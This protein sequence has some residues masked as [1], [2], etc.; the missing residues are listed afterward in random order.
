MS[1]NNA[2][3]TWWSRL[4][5]QGLLLSPVV[6]VERYASAPAAARF[7]LLDNLRND[8]N[9]FDSY[10]DGLKENAERDEAAILKWTDALL[11][12][13]VQC[14]QGQIAKQHAIPPNLTAPVRIGSRTETLRPH[15]VVFADPSQKAVALL[16]IADTSP[17][18]G[19]GRGRNKYAQFLELLRGT[20]HRL[21]LLTNGSQFRLIYAG[22]DFESWCEWESDRWFDGGEGTEELDGL[23]QLLSP[24]SLAPTKSGMSSLLDAVEE[25]RKRQAD[26]S[27]V[28]RENVRQAV[29]LLLED[30]S[31]AHRTKS[32]LFSSLSR[33]ERVRV[34]AAGEELSS[35]D[36]HPLTDAEAHEALLQ[37]TVRIVMRLVVCL[38]AESRQLLP[39]NDP[40]YAQAYG[41]RSLYELLDEAV[42][43]EGGTHVLFNRQMAW[44]R[45]MALFRLIHHGSSHGAF[46]MRAYGGAL[47]R[48]GD[49]KSLNAVDRALHILE[50]AVSVGDA[51]VYHVLRKLLRGPLPVVK[52]HQKTFVDGPVDYT[53]LRTEFIGLIYEGLLDYRLKRTDEQTGPQVFLNLGREPVLPLARLR[54]MLENDRKGLKDLLTTLRKEKVTASVASEE[55]DADEEAEEQNEAEEE[56]TE[57]IVAEPEAATVQIQRTGDYMDAVEA[58]KQWAREAV[59][60]A[61]LIGKQAKRE[62]DSEYQTRIEAEATK[63]INRVVAPGEFYLV[64]AGNTRKGTGTFYTRPQL[65]VPT[66]HRTLEPL[67][68]NKS[69]LPPGEG[70][71]EGSDSVTTLIPKAPEDILSLK[72]CDPACGSASFLVAALHYLTEALYKSLC[73]HRKLDDPSQAKRVTL[74]YGRP[75]NGNEGDELLPFPPDDPNRGE[76]FADRVKALLRRH[77]VERC[78]YGVDINAL[79]VELARVSLWVETLDPDLPFSF[80]DHKIKV[81]NSLVGCW[82]D[83][84]EDYPLKAW[85]REGGDGKDGPRSQR[86]E[87]FLKGERIGKRRT[88][89]GRIKREMRE[90]IESRFDKNPLLF[91]KT[92]TTTNQVIAE[93]R[94]EY[95]KLHNL[96]IGDPDQRERFYRAHVLASPALRQ[97]KQA[98]DEWCAVWFWPADEESLKHVP[99]PL[100]FHNHESGGKDDIVRKLSEELKFFHWEL[101]FPDVFTSCRAGFD[102]MIGNPPWDVMK[103]NSQEFFTEFDPL[104]RTYDKQAA[105]RKQQELFDDVPGVADQWD[106]YNAQFKAM[107]NWARNVASPFDMTLVRGKQGES[108]A[109]LWAAHRAKS[110]GYADAEHPF[111]LQGSADLNLYKMFAEFFWRL[112]QSDGRLGVILPTGIYSDFGTRPLREEFLERGQIDL[113][114]AFQNEK[115][116]FSAAHHSF[117]QVALLA[118]RG[119]QTKTFLARFRMGV[120]DSPLAHEIPDDLLRGDAHAMAFTPDDVRRNSPNSL[121][122]VELRTVRDFVIFRRI[123][124]HSFLIGN[125]CPGWEITYATEFHMTNDSKHFSPLEKWESKG[126]K[127]DIFGRWIGPDNGVAVP[128]YQGGMVH[129]FNF[130]ANGW[131]SG[132]G[133]SAKWT[134]IPFDDKRPSPKYLMSEETLLGWGK[135]VRHLKVGQRRIARASDTRTLIA[136]PLSGYAGGDTLAVLVVGG[137]NYQRTLVLASVLS[138]LSTD[139]VARL[140]VA[141][142]HLDWYQLE[143]LPI[144]IQVM[145]QEDSPT[146][147]CL[148]VLCGRLTF[149]HRRFAPEWLK[150]AHLYPEVF[151]F[152]PLA[153]ST[154]HRSAVREWKH[155]WAVTEAERLRLRVEIEALCADLYG[156][157]PDDFDWIVRDDP[158]DPKGFYRVDRN[159]P[160]R[161]RLTGLAAAAFRALKDGRWSAESVASLSNDE[162]FDILGIPE[163]TN[164]D[165]AKARG[166]PGP[167]ILKRDGCH[168][169]QPENFPPDDP[170][171]GWTWDDCWNDAIALLGSREAVEKYIA[172]KPEEDADASNNGNDDEPF[173]LKADKPKDKQ[174]KMF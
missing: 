170:R 26:L 118:T 80:L 13:Y 23:R 124:D 174:K 18:I 68:F 168:V 105:L 117:K 24:E 4:R 173:Q 164:A 61:G 151:G 41:V 66:V 131:S 112:L 165:A 113:L 154:V 126:Y 32:D 79:A 146:S 130:S 148:A 132:L 128:L 43:T 75:K 93:A 52:G 97:L 67:C 54:D 39:V 150:L 69:P 30:V 2:P 86:I 116:V 10:V 158:T 53:D 140:K 12:K 42:R 153:P 71:G 115:R 3:H 46:A 8:F 106:Q 31:T 99:T 100:G 103:P 127:P 81:G 101:E 50:Y 19:R 110:A 109:N 136:C 91:P 122:L 133:R 77:V 94:L 11:E 73:H 141:G 98:M 29:E 83:R 156:L 123:Y 70:Q 35:Q 134:A 48:P 27:S 65:A 88:G 144:P 147:A 152:A 78:I 160:F 63:L 72:V 6:M 119:G 104:Y 172:E 166:L 87:E 64:R 129:H 95:E 28:L 60:L 137:G 59:V 33:R 89:D 149:L 40:I 159:L 90:V 51:T 138:S 161:E 15:R 84:V 37:A 108:L 162:F 135:Y 56:T 120:G 169:W 17:H 5:H 142:T 82:L 145:E 36:A 20:G 107:G 171:H 85:E 44:S 62:S 45:L 157:E 9:R 121:S 7:P 14:G 167:L 55:E 47:F 34:R 38:F 102:A 76:M 111:R 1:Q 16:V 57:E 22:I 21:G 163:L 74:P 155:W 143:Q 139:S 58:S 25:S 96:P 92:K 114:Y 125:K 49:A